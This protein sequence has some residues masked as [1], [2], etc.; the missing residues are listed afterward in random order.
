MK[1]LTTRV[2]AWCT[3]SQSKPASNLKTNLVSNGSD[4]VNLNQKREKAQALD[5]VKYEKLKCLRKTHR[6]PYKECVDCDGGIRLRLKIMH[7]GR[8]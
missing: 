6:I 5:L 3:L 2:G 7:C 4:Q 1:I 8:M